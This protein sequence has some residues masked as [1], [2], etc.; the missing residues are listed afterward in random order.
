M[1]ATE[2]FLHFKGKLA[3]DSDQIVILASLMGALLGVLLA[4]RF[5]NWISP[6]VKK[7]LFG[8]LWKSR[9]K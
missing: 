9:K 2:L 7:A 8:A 5:C 1:N 4:N 6:L 3:F